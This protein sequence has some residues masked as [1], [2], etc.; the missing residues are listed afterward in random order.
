LEAV[1]MAFH[2]ATKPSVDPT[3][4]REMHYGAVD[5][6][7]RGHGMVRSFQYNFGE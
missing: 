5:S 6:S 3:A 4:T 1:I 2:G 7:E